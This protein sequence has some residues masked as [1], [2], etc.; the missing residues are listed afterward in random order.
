MLINVVLIKKK[1]CISYDKV[2][3][4]KTAIANSVEKREKKE[5]QCIY[6]S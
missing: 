6:T 4:I 5:Q 2:L 3:K 1:S